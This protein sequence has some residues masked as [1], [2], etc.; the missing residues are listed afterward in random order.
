MVTDLANYFNE[1]MLDN[2]TISTNSTSLHLT[3]CMTEHQ[4]REMVQTFMAHYFNSNYGRSRLKELETGT[5]MKHLNVGDMLNWKVPLPPTLSEQKAIA[6]A[7][8]EVDELIAKLEKLIEKKKAIKQGV[9]QEL[10][11]PKEGW[12]KLKLRENKILFF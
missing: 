4:L 12:V 9:M 10:L 7:L 11:R 6:T 2:S 5:T 1:T 3:N 8:S